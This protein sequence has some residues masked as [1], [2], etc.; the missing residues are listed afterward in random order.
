[1]GVLAELARGGCD[2][3]AFGAYLSSA[4]CIVGAEPIGV[5]GKTGVEDEMIGDCGNAACIA[6]S[7]PAT[8]GVTDGVFD[9]D[10][11]GGW[12]RYVGLFPAFIVS[13]PLKDIGTSAP[14]NE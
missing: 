3:G 12:L 6:A 8:N 11:C 4:A 13:N 7:L 1:M 14:D 2:I 10:C 9:N 5:T